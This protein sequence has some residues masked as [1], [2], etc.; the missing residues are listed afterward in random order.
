LRRRSS[1]RDRRA[2]LGQRQQ[3]HA[4][5]ALGLSAHQQAAAVQVV[6]DLGDRRAAEHGDRDDLAGAQWPAGTRQCAE[7][8]EL[9]AVDAVP[10]QVDVEAVVADRRDALD[11][12]EHLDGGG[13]QVGIGLGPLR[14]HPVHGVDGHPAI[15]ADL[16][17]W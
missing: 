9:R 16:V 14:A 12:A 5:V 8:A 15:V 13:V 3:H 11:P 6:G 2:R 10:F 1:E 17:H 7:H 4:A